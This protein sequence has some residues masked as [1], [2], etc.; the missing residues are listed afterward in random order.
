MQ[1]F[2]GNTMAGTFYIIGVGPG[3]PELLTLKG[4]RILKECDVWLAPKAHQNGQSTALTIAEHAIGQRAAK[5]VTHRFPM[6]Q[7][8]RNE[9]PDPELREAWQEAARLVVETLE[10]GQDIAFPTLGDPAIYST[11]FYVCEA[12]QEYADGVKVEVVPG[13]SAIG[14]TA[15]VAQLPLCLGDEHLVVI[16]ATFND[17]RIREVLEV[18]DSVAFMKVHKVMPKLIRLLEEADLV[19]Q[20]VLIEKTS[21]EDQK[22][23]TD[24]REVVDRDLHYFS[25]MI[26]R[27]ERSCK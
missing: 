20:A 8:F 10:T 13:V 25:T 3:D 16:P 14:A 12:L 24:I 21:L 1:K 26:I 5:V 19:E 15:A 23:W 27:K 17:A 7:V 2:D 4:A 11:A 18:C 9:A 22:V 6:K